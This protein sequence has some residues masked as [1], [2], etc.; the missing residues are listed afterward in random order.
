MRHRD[1]QEG[2]YTASMTVAGSGRGVDNDRPTGIC[3]AVIGSMTQAM[4]AQAVLAEAAI[5]AGV[6][7]IS[8]AQSHNGCAYGVDFSCTQ[9]GNVRIVLEKAGVRV[10]QY[11]RG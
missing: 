10:R 4:R 3:T 6:T 1:P 11:L 2:M 8:S 5:R 9:S 7:K